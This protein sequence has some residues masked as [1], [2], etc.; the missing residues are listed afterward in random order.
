MLVKHYFCLFLPVSPYQYLVRERLR[1]G[2]CIVEPPYHCESVEARLSCEK[3][4]EWQRNLLPGNRATNVVAVPSQTAIW[5]ERAKTMVQNPLTTVGV[6]SPKTGARKRA[7]VNNQD[8]DAF[9]A[10]GGSPPEPFV[11]LH[12]ENYGSLFLIRPASPAGKTW[13]NEHIGTD[14]Q[15]LGDAVVCELR[16]VEDIFRGASADGLVCR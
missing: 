15:L 16:F 1:A 10:S 12:F 8:N 4:Q 9:H 2:V 13:L 7:L 3:Y 14:A 6:P 5:P 11:D